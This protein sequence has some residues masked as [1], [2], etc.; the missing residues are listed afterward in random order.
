MTCFWSH[1][2]KNGGCIKKNSS[3]S[4]TSGEEIAQRRDSDVFIID[5]NSDGSDCRNDIQPPLYEC[6]V[7]ESSPPDYDVAVK[8]PQLQ[9]DALRL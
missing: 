5:L 8:L 4:D 9:T 6:L 1:Y 2:L 3:Y 7:E